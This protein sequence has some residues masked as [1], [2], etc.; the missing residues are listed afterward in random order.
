MKCPFVAEQKSRK[1][2]KQT[3]MKDEE[4]TLRRTLFLCTKE[5]FAWVLSKEKLLTHRWIE[6]EKGY[7]E[8]PLTKLFYNCEARTSLLVLALN[9]AALRN[10][11]NFVEIAVYIVR[12]LDFEINIKSYFVKDKT[13]GEIASALN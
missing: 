9:F 6:E 11:Q 2:E 3:E 4:K 1:A 10:G 13:S 7:G 12:S 5:H 8:L